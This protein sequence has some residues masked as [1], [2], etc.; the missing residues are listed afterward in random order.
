[1]EIRHLRYF[2]AVAEQLNFTRAAELLHVTQPTLSQQ[3]VDLESQLGVQLFQRGKRGVSLTSAGT[4]MLEEA[5]A[6]LAR[7]EQCLQR[8]AGF[9]KGD[10]GTLTIGVLEFFEDTLLPELTLSL[11][12]RH[13][14]IRVLWQQYPLEQLRDNLANGK[15]DLNFT[16]I[17]QHLALS[18][19]VKTVV[20]KD[21]LALV[22]PKG[23]EFD[24][25]D[26][27]DPIRLSS[28]LARPLFLWK[29]WYQDEAGQLVRKLHEF[30]PTLDVRPTEKINFC[31]MNTLIENGYTILPYHVVINIKQSH[32]SYFRLPFEEAELDTA[33]LYRSDNQNPCIPYFMEEALRF[34]SLSQ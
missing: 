32:F 22:L 14:G 25:V 3:I 5:R 11:R 18:G 15:L 23:T 7:R 29:E 20:T 8:M 16:I 12:R 4:A 34:L 17:P 33:L 26:V 27:F 31:L 30:C 6:I 24:G 2:L 13:P 28:L 19:V 9:Q 21:R 1:M 10:V